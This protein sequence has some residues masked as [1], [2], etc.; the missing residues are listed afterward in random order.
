MTSFA[1]VFVVV[2]LD[3]DQRT[4]QTELTHQI[5]TLNN[6]LEALK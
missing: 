2:M 3:D 1:R 4:G 6:N 5:T